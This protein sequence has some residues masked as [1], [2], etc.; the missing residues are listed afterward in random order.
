[1][2]YTKYFNNDNRYVNLLANEKKLLKKYNE[3]WGKIKILSN[4]EFD[5]KPFYNNKFVST[6]IKI[7]NDAIHTKFKYKKYYKIRS[8]V[9][10]YL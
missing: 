5:K 10:I 2:G 9:N 8:I 4:K 3:I 1:M 7:Y 6:K